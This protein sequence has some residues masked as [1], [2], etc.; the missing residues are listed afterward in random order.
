M[1][2]FP[3]A[4]LALV[5]GFSLHES[6]CALCGNRQLRMDKFWCRW[7]LDVLAYCQAEMNWILGQ[8]TIDF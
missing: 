6:L 7:M 3:M 8:D 2:A 5:Q 1:H 4:C